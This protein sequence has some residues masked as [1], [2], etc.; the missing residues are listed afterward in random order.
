MRPRYILIFG[1]PGAGKGTQG[2]R[3]AA[4]LGLAYI[5][6]GD[7]FRQHVE[8]GTELGRI[9][10]EYM[11]RGLY[12]PDEV[13]VKMVLERLG[14]PDAERGAVLDGFPRTLPQAEALEKALAERGAEVDLVFYIKISEA[15]AQRRVQGRWVCRNCQAAYNLETNP[16]RVPGRCDVCGG[17]LY[18]RTDETPETLRRRFEVFFEQTVPV[19]EY[20]RARGLL[21]EINGK[22]PIDAVFRELKAA[23]DRVFGRI[24]GSGS[25]GV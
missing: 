1:P 16:P 6:S 13:T 22:Q 25:G 19:L 11:D 5:A 15:E 2:R 18:Q 7:I 8:A 21:V 3:L 4:E 20:Y 9:A 24:A 17:E 10:K 12:V 23:A 14:R